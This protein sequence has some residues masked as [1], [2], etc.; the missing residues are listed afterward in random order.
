VKE[1]SHR[2]AHRCYRSG[3]DALQGT[4]GFPFM[5]A[6]S[7]R[8]TCPSAIAT[9]KRMLKLI[10]NADD[11]GL[12]EAVN[13]GILE[14]HRNGILT[15]AS[16]MAN[17]VAFEHAI[18]LCRSIPS[19]DL[20]IHLTLVEEEPLLSAA[21]I[22][23]LVDTGGRLHRHATTFMR[24]YVAGKIHLQDVRSELEA[25]IQKVLS[26]GFEVSHLD[27]HQH[28]HLLPQI[29]RITI[30]LAKKY[31]IPA[32]RI[33]REHLRP[34]MLRRAGGISRLCQLFVLNAF[35]QLGRKMPAR[36]TDH[37]VGFFFGGNLHKENLH[38]LIQSLPIS[39]TCELMCHPGMEDPTTRYSHWGYH[40]SEELSALT[41]PEIAKVVR[42]QGVDLI[43]Y[44]QLAHL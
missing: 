24:K 12:S 44:R 19:L 43:S 14:A 1:K 4:T 10:V 29:L 17:G 18:R 34:Y 25:Q 30:A 3:V 37:F 13:E 32:I 23:S 40:W 15:S 11:L 21:A 27:S 26:Q 20:G 2:A 42:R 7:F 16:V 36:R 31:N 38:T 33:P 39:G 28:L 35:C 8:V 9:T 6:T 41:D 5:A 22:P